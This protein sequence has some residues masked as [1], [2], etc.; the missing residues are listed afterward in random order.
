MR[1]FMRNMSL[2]RKCQRG[3]LVIEYVVMFT[4]IVA[5]IIYAA[6]AFVKPSVN[7]FFNS[8]TKIIDNVTNAIETA[9]P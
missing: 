8:T 6:A 2:M 7:R 3:Q 5:V 1:D 4:V 9:Y